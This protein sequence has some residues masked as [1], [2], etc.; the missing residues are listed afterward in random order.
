MKS[1]W[2]RSG[3][4]CHVT[5]RIESAV[6]ASGIVGTRNWKI[7]QRSYLPPSL[8][9]QNLLAPY[10]SEQLGFFPLF[11]LLSLPHALSRGELT[12]APWRCVSSGFLMTRGWEHSES[13][14][15]WNKICKKTV[16]EIILHR[17]VNSTWPFQPGRVSAS[18]LVSW[19]PR[20]GHLLNKAAYLGRS[21][22]QGGSCQKGSLIDFWLVRL[23]FLVLFSLPFSR[24]C[25]S[26]SSF[27]R[28]GKWNKSWVTCQSQVRGQRIVTRIK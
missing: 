21:E 27:Y 13:N 4:L 18:G 3:G 17:R 12:L 25:V 16:R 6:K 23:K 22:G 11:S 10:V 15:K 24:E 1:L 20:C 7:D 26:L 28:W 8:L 5:A 14:S 19:G 9:L 2:L